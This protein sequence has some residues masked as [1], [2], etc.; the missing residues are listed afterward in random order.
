MHRLQSLLIHLVPVFPF[1]TMFSSIL[2]HFYTHWKR[3]K[4]RGF[5][6]FSGGIAILQNTEKHVNKSKQWD[7]M[8]YQ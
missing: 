7:E 2:K 8:S 6:T 4:T 1:V 3:Q 5:L